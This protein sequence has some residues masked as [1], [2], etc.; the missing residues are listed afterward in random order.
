[1]KN[2]E[3]FNFYLLFNSILLGHEAGI[4]MKDEMLKI[5]NFKTAGVISLCSLC[6]YSTYDLSNF[7]RHMRSHSGE[8]PFRCHL[9]D[10]SF[11]RKENL[12][13]HFF[14]HQQQ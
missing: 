5:M 2:F 8:H 12:K 6:P 14:S 3:T 7:K 9:C 11:T 10:K 4:T 13:K 1:M